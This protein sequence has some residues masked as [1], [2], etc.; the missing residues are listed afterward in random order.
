MEL[1]SKYL[2]N[3]KRKKWSFDMPDIELYP[4]VLSP[5]G[6]SYYL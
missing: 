1:P 5:A 3:K 6:K 4:K 2:S